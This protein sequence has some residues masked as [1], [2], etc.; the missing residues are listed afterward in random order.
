M[1][2]ENPWGL[3]IDPNSG[4]RECA[5]AIDPTAMTARR[6]RPP[7]I[8]GH[9]YNDA[10]AHELPGTADREFEEHDIVMDYKTGRDPF[11]FFTVPEDVS[12]LRTLGLAYLLARQAELDLRPHSIAGPQQVILS[13]LHAPRGSAPAIYADAVE[14]GDLLVHNERLRIA[15]ARKGDGSI[16]AGHMCNVCPARYDCPLRVGALLRGAAEVVEGGDQVL[17]KIADASD[18]IATS[19]DIG[20][21]HYF[22]SRLKALG[23]AADGLMKQWVIDH[24]EDPPVRPDGRVLVIKTKE[25][26]R[27]SKQSI[28][29]ALGRYS[30]ERLIEELRAQGVLETKEQ[31]E[32][33]AERD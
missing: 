6:I 33:H 11:D 7:T 20:K 25:V 14:A 15:M 29:R 3:V 22:L 5:Y 16:R 26:E 23:A 21:L 10:L 2:G 19:D 27:L 31:V 17:A 9:I 12:Q 4:R 32:L 1:K 30:G 24:P 28:Y 13:V 8:E 18:V